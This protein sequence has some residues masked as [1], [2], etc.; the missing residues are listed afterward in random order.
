MLAKLTS[1]TT[2]P[3]QAT[4]FSRAFP[5]TMTDLRSWWY[6][7]PGLIHVSGQ[8]LH[9]TTWEN[10]FIFENEQYANDFLAA[11]N[12]YKTAR[13]LYNDANGMT[14]EHIITII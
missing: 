1:T 12:E 10:I 14:T 9:P 2:N 3:Q 6:T 8:E 4:W 7:N 5:E 13:S 11:E